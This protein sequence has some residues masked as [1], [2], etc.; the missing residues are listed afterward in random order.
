MGGMLTSMPMR[1]VIFAYVCNHIFFCFRGRRGWGGA[2]RGMLKS[3]AMTFSMSV[4]IL[5]RG[6]RVCFVTAC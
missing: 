4:R 5:L 2:K 6:G 1:L 3:M